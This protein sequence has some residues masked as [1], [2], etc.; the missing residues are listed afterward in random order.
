MEQP[1]KNMTR[2]I[3][4]VPGP[5]F[6]KHLWTKWCNANKHPACILFLHR[7]NL[8][9]M[10]QWAL[11]WQ[12]IM[13]RECLQSGTCAVATKRHRH[14]TAS[15]ATSC[16]DEVAICL[17]YECA[18]GCTTTDEPTDLQTAASALVASASKQQ[19]SVSHT[20][21][22]CVEIARSASKAHRGNAW[23]VIGAS[24]A[25]NLLTT[26]NAFTA[27]MLRE[28]GSTTNMLNQLERVD[29]ATWL[30]AVSLFFFMI[31][32]F[33]L[34]NISLCHSHGQACFGNGSF[35]PESFILQSQALLLGFFRQHIHQLLPLC[36]C[37]CISLT[38]EEEEELL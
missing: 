18:T 24:S 14:R 36:T 15:C 32:S 7:K 3:I 21:S 5:Y 33:S 10:F 8:K 1:L 19:L 26:T 20:I 34:S 22:H 4:L 28:C 9:E 13:L 11:Q 17:T 30:Q 37:I 38:T 12:T 23:N 27:A 16:T 31:C 6:P 35:L 25:R 29:T 2:S